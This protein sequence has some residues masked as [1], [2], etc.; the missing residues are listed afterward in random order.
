MRSCARWRARSAPISAITVDRPGR[1]SVCG[2]WTRCSCAGADVSAQAGGS[3][4]TAPAADAALPITI[5]LMGPTG[6]GK[7]EL[8]LALARRLPL[9]VVSVDS[10]MIYRGMDIGTAKPPADVLA[11]TPH[12]LID[13]LDPAQSYSAERFR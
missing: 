13:I 1:S 3:H 5:L 11:R 7:T 9:D 12:R 2:S 10:A 6:A 4:A 8:A